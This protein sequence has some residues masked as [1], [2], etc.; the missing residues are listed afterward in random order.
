M[1]CGGIFAFKPNTDDIFICSDGI[2]M[3]QKE[4]LNIVLGVKSLLHTSPLEPNHRKVLFVEAAST[5]IWSTRGNVL[6]VSTYHPLSIP[7]L[8]ST[9]SRVN[10]VI[11]FVYPGR[12]DINLSSIKE[13]STLFHA[14]RQLLT[15]S[16]GGAVSNAIQQAYNKVNDV[17]MNPA[18]FYKMEPLAG[19]DFKISGESPAE[20]AS[21]TDAST[22]DTST[23]GQYGSSAGFNS[24]N[25][26]SGFNVPIETLNANT[27]VSSSNLN[28]DNRSIFHTKF[29]QT[30][31]FTAHGTQMEKYQVETTVK[32]LVSGSP[33]AGELNFAI[34]PNNLLSNCKVNT[35]VIEQTELPGVYKS[36]KPFELLKDIQKVLIIENTGTQTNFP[37]IFTAD[38]DEKPDT[39]DIRI[40]ITSP[41]IIT[42][43]YLAAQVMG[44]DNIKG[45]DGVS[46]QLDGSNLLAILT[47]KERDDDGTP[48]TFEYF[49]SGTKLPLFQ[50]PS[51]VN[52]KCTLKGVTL[53]GLDVKTNPNYKFNLGVVDKK[54]SITNSIWK[55]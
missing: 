1:F 38:F 49:I 19:G 39:V 36:T 32:I 7:L 53:G 6:G 55:L 34:T 50:K 30:A 18:I 28:P 5:Y 46:I 42:E 11:S 13:R 4:L 21:T 43:L 24:N 15:N 22:N 12:E 31:T 27:P 26:T 54:L 33:D 14:F 48:K 9:L 37:F 20:D 52:I 40:K 35:K 2:E 23:Q 44:L 29:S 41:H 16:A 3:N 47:P 51:Q 45:G 8:S 17:A 25:F 10:N